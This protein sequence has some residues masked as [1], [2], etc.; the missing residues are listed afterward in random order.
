MDIQQSKLEAES[1]RFAQAISEEK[2]LEL[3]KTC[4]T[5]CALWLL[6]TLDGQLSEECF[7]KICNVCGFEIEDLDKKN[8]D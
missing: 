8:I 6:D 4:W 3:V 1:F 7:K 5:G 2:N